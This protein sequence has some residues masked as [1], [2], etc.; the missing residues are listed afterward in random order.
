[1][2]TARNNEDMGRLSND[3]IHAA[4]LSDW[5]ILAS[6]LHATFATGDFRTGADFVAGLTELA[7]RADHHPEV[8]LSYPRVSVQLSSHDIGGLSERDVNLAREISALAA[9]QEISGAPAEL[10]LLEL[11]LDTADPERV[12]PFWSAVLTGTPDNVD[13]D[14]VVDP[15]G[16]CR[17]CGYSGPIR[18]PNR[19]S[20]SIWICGSVVSR[21]RTGS[22]P[23]RLPV[24]PSS[25]TAR[26]PSPCW[27][28][29]KATRSASVWPRALRPG[30][31]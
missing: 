24:A 6:T 16:V 27:P 28:T 25:T 13:G 2:G 12:G 10:A 18:T 26:R 3:E 19:G 11:A 9:D 22:P 15:L 1:M 17:C 31:R 21:W 4:G 30:N 14:D 5:R 8:R 23:P 29:P 20:A 7:E